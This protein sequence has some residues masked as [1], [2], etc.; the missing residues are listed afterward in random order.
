MVKKAG[1][2]GYVGASTAIAGITSWNVDYTVAML[3]TT[4]FSASGIRSVIPG[5][6]QWEGSF[7]GY[8]DGAPRALGSATTVNLWLAESASAGNIWKG[9]AYING[10]HANT[11][12]D[13]IVGYNYDFTGTLSVSPASTG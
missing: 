7:A 6:E 9:T 10:V 1:S 4:D 12:F 5:V 3:D 8:K 13:G 11:N 2:T